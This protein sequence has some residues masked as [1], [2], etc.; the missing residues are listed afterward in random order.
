M[1]GLRKGKLF[2]SEILTKI[3][4]EMTLFSKKC[5]SYR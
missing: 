2:L 4:V 5:H 3:T 1:I